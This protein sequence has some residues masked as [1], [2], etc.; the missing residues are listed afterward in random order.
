MKL[1]IT[2]LRITP[3]VKGEATDKTHKDQIDVL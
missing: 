1:T 2:L 3:T